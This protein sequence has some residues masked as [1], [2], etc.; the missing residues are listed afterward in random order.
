[1]K[2]KFC[3]KNEAEIWVQASKRND[4]KLLTIEEYIF[5]KNARHKLLQYL[6]NI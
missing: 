2:I 4:V 3:E 5:N 1:M 6:D